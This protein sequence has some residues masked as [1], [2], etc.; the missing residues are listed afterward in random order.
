[1]DNALINFMVK[2]MRAKGWVDQIIIQVCSYLSM[3]ML[4]MDP[5]LDVK[6][7]LA[8]DKN[9]TLHMIVVDCEDPNG[10]CSRRETIAGTGQEWNVAHD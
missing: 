2:V 5:V 9:G 4:Q 8:P 6:R 10:S 3:K 1:M 7:S